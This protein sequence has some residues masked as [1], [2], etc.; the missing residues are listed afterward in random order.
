MVTETRIQRCARIIGARCTRL[1]ARSI[2]ATS[3][4]RPQCIQRHNSRPTSTNCVPSWIVTSLNL[5]VQKHSTK[6]ST[7]SSAREFGLCYPA[8][9]SFVDA[10]HSPVDY[11]QSCAV[12]YRDVVTEQEADLLSKTILA[13]M[14]RYVG[15]AFSFFECCNTLHAFNVGALDDFI[16]SDSLWSN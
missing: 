16:S 3:P 6:A 2:T 5:R 10:R 11:E 1:Q 14:R 7:D 15:L 9:Y 12:V 13:R 4:L 8:E